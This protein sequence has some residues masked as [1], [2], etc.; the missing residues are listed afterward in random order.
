MS[1][2]QRE[3]QHGEAGGP[4]PVE[5]A[6]VERRGGVTPLLVT[7]LALAGS[8]AA[9]TLQFPWVLASTA[10]YVNGSAPVHAGSREQDRRDAPA[11]GSEEKPQ[12]FIA[13]DIRIEGMRYVASG[14]AA[15][16]PGSNPD[17]H[18]RKC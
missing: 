11:S 5:P 4:S 8:A 15:P 6:P 14:I 1:T 2:K 10:A 18:E 17:R 7:L 3:T 13:D 12:P 16:V 9:V